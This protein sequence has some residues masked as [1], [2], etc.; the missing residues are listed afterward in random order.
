V[1]V[2]ANVYVTPSRTVRGDL[3]V[4]NGRITHVGSRG[5]ENRPPQ[6]RV[7]EANG[8]SVVPL[9]VDSSVRARSGQTDAYTGRYWV[10][11]G[12]ITYLDDTGFW[13]FGELL[14]G[15]LHHA[16]FVMHKR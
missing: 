15:V 13:A 4:E 14:D 3:W 5:N 11:D 9:L 12:R 10:H 1:V 16:G 2:D 7:I 8:A 6:A